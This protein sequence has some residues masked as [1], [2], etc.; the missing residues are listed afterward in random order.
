MSA[1]TLS[2]GLIL[3]S[4]Q[5]TVPAAS[6]SSSAVMFS[7]AQD[8]RWPGWVH[9]TMRTLRALLQLPRNW[10]GYGANEVQESAVNGS[11]N[12]LVEIMN[13]DTLAPSIVPLS[14]GG[15]QIEWHR[16]GRNLEIEFFRDEAPS[17]Y[18]YETDNGVEDEGPAHENLA[19]LRKI[20]AEMK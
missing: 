11:W 6:G 3:T 4:Q 17:F 2:I 1:T 19:L 16:H 14:D 5:Y 12:L 9:P 20:L 8:S 15:I 7:R 18:F 13:D 10:D